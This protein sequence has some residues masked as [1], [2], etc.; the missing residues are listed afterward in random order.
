MRYAMMREER[1]VLCVLSLDV[2]IGV[3]LLDVSCYII[4]AGRGHGYERLHRN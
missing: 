1:N 2:V 4:F 3:Y